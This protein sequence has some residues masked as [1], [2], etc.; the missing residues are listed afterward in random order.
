MEFHQRGGNDTISL[1]VSFFESWLTWIKIQP[2][3]LMAVLLFC[4]SVSGQGKWTYL[5]RTL[6]S[7]L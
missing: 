5:I 7:F 1:T 6:F 4:V 2:V 3:H